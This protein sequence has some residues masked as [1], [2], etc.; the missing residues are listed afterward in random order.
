MI[1]WPAK[2]KLE[3][4]FEKCER[5]GSHA[6]ELTAAPQQKIWKRISLDDKRETKQQQRVKVGGQET[7]A[8]CT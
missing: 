1:Q 8:R 2:N 6:A 3:N 5:R 4:A 7:H